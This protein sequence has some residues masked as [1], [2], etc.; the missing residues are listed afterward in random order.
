MTKRDEIINVTA[1]LIHS[2]GYESTS[3]KDILTEAEIGK[4][5]FYHYFSSKRELGIAVVDH[6]VET[7]EQ[8]LIKNILNTD[9]TGRQKL[10]TMLNWAVDYHEAQAK[11]HGCPFGNLALEM[12]EHDEVFREKVNGLL[13][14]WIES[15]RDAL[16][17]FVEGDAM[18]HAQTIVAQLEGGI[19]LMK[20]YQD[21]TILRNIADTIR[22]YYLNN[23]EFYK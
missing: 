8:H 21:V 9:Q 5:Q 4:G 14:S 11:M 10:D 16:E 6:F 1:Q 13:H 2:K 3:L 22:V 19:L 23:K 20:S 7:W 12:S 18:K 15:L 17:E